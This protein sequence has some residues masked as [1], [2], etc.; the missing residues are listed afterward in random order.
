MSNV[1]ILGLSLGYPIITCRSKILGQGKVRRK[2]DV[3]VING[4][5]DFTDLLDFH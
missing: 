5:D 1:I 4:H 3:G 2:L